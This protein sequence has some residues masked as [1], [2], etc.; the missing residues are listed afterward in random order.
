MYQNVKSVAARTLQNIL[1]CS[2]ITIKKFCDDWSSNISKVE[3]NLILY[4]NAYRA[5]Y[6]WV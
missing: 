2:V 5:G 6:N 4:I 3:K 1:L